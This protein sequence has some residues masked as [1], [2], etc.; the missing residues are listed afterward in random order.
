MKCDGEKVLPFV[1]RQLFHIVDEGINPVVKRDEWFLVPGG[2]YL[3]L[4]V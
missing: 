4:E 2:K 1:K 3:V